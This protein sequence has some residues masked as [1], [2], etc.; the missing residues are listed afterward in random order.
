[1]PTFICICVG[2]VKKRAL[3]VCAAGG[4]ICVRSIVRSGGTNTLLSTSCCRWSRCFRFRSVPQKDFVAFIPRRLNSSH[5]LWIVFS[6]GG[7]TG[8]KPEQPQSNGSRV[9]FVECVWTHSWA[10][11]QSLE[12]PSRLR[13]SNIR[14]F[15]LGADW[16]HVR[17]WL[18]LLSAHF[19]SPFHFI[20]I[21]AFLQYFCSVGCLPS[22]LSFSITAFPLSIFLSLFIQFLSS[23]LPLPLRALDSAW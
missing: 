13:P 10:E 4:C 18:S 6:W 9:C 3:V 14:L 16:N 23:S 8:Y 21:L 22:V 11:H 15:N 17:D 2:E 20:A 7:F 1:M 19:F 5:V 12:S